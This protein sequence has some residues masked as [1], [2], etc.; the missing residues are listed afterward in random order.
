M[1]ADTDGNGLLDL[2]EFE[3]LVKDEYVMKTM[4]DLGVGLSHE[5]LRRA[6]FM[7][8]VDE[9]GELTIEEFT[10]GLGQLQQG[11]TTKH[12]VS[13]DYALQRVQVKLSG[14]IDQMITVAET[15]DMTNEKLMNSLQRLNKSV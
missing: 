11:L 10:M 12:V 6:F 1:R 13:I 5:E 4:E 7:L 8:D 9:S 14:K 15:C 2:K 3:E